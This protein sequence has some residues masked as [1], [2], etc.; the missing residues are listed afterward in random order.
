[1]LDG[2]WKTNIFMKSFRNPLLIKWQFAL[3]FES[4][5]LF[6]EVMKLAGV[7]SRSHIVESVKKTDNA[8]VM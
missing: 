5:T 2:R 1:M 4:R 8:M 7:K 3:L 6:E